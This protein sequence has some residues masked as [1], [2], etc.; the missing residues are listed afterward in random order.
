MRAYPVDSG[1]A[2]LVPDPD[3]DA[4]FTLV[5]DGAP[6]SHVDLGDPTRLEFEYV[7]RIGHV[8]DRAAPPGEPLSAL[9]LGGGGLTLPRYLTATRPGSPQRVVERDGALV[10]LVR[11]DLP[12]G[13]D[14]RP[15]IRVGDAREVL[16]TLRPDSFDVVVVDVYAGAR[17]PV[18]CA[19]V[20]FVTAAD[21]VLRSG[22]LYLAN[23]ADGAGCAFARAQVATVRAVFGEVLMI[24]DAAVLR[25]RRFGN[26]VLVAGHWPLP[27]AQLTR[28]AAGDA[29]PARVMDG[30]QL[31]RFTG[32]AR[33]V[34][35]AGAAASPQPPAGPLGLRG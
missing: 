29:F 7:R 25:G 5:L 30:G 21:R 16:E 20:E 33:P 4:A 15:R 6:Q 10:E 32:G 12:L 34:T 14:C 19:S 26:L 9:H 27:V 28:L 2:E 24:A 13:R 17:I 31:D 35:D 3:S 1:S 23:V 11:R 22:G 8:L 18:S